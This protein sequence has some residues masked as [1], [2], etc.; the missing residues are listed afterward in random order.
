MIKLK[1]VI[2][3]WC[4]HVCYGPLRDVGHETYDR[5]NDESSEHTGEGI[6]AADDDRISEEQT[7]ARNCLV[8][9]HY[10]ILLSICHIESD[11]E[12][13]C[14]GKKKML[15]CSEIQNFHAR[16]CTD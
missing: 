15:D 8:I 1:S 2:I 12:A 4:S 10:F 9:S 13:F 6:D 5:E 14:A 16:V 7:K 11:K 3:T